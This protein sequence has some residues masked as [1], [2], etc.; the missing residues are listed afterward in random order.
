MRVDLY[1]PPDLDEAADTWEANCAPGAVAAL[2][3]RPLA[4]VRRGFP[5]FPERPWT[6]PTQLT[7]AVCSLLPR[8]GGNWTTYG[9]AYR[10][11]SPVEQ[12]KLLPRKGLVVVQ[13]DGPWCDL[14]NKRAAYRYTHVAA[15]RHTGLGP[16]VYDVNAGSDAAPGGWVNVWAWA[17]VLE[18]LRETYKRSTGWFVRGV[19]ELD[20]VDLSAG[21]AV[22]TEGA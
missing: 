21:Q 18:E 11:Q 5:W 6:S 9:P 15:S 13:F 7:D 3:G 8:A 12:F 20:G 2:L 19:L 16:Y 22:S 14:A 1:T 17:G 10:G 4:D